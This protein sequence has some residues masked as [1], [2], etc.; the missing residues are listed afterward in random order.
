[1]PDSKIAMP[2]KGSKKKAAPAKVAKAEPKAKS[3]SKVKATAEPKAKAKPTTA[4][5]RKAAGSGAG[6]APAKKAAA[7]VSVADP[8]APPH[9]G[10]NLEGEK[11]YCC[12][13]AA[14]RTKTFGVI[15]AAMIR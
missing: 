9:R 15:E 3:G 12:S 6:D 14:D 11:V 2:P 8:S 10:V 5:K 7:S 1:M 13:S 4:S